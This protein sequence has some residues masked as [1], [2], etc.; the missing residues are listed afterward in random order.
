MGVEAKATARQQKRNN[1][2][3]MP[4]LVKEIS[5]KIRTKGEKVFDIR[6]NK[7][8]I[9]ARGIKGSRIGHHQV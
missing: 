8:P 1:V 9:L 6:E 4:L 7:F 5:R 2:K 3:R